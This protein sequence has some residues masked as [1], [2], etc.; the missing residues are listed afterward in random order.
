MQPNLVKLG[1][2]LK[3]REN[4]E[5]DGFLIGKVISPP[6]SIQISIDENIILDNS[7]LIF[8]AS[9]LAG[10]E[11]VIDVTSAN[12][13]VNDVTVTSFSG[14]IITTD[15]LKKD[16]QVILVPSSN[17]QMYIVIDKAVTL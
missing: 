16:E 15:T 7:N 12:I 2:L 10:Y 3:E 14:K 13:Q 11:R 4:K 8:S 1:K 5:Y 9:L 6:P 17:N